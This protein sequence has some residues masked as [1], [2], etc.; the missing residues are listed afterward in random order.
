VV[1]FTT[2]SRAEVP[3]KKENLSQEMMMII[4]II[5]SRNQEICY[6]LE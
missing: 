6:K 3:G 4:I 1:G 2:G 5:N